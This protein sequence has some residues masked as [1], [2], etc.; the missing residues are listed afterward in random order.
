MANFVGRIVSAS[1][2][3]GLDRDRV[4]AFVPTFAAPED[5]VAPVVTVISASPILR[6]DPW[7][8]E[9]TDETGLAL[10]TIA[11]ELR[12]LA[13]PP[14][15]A[16]DGVAFS[17]QYSPG[18]AVEAIEDGFRFT[19]YRADGWIASPSFRVLAVDTGGNLAA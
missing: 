3:S 8:V 14:E 6:Y 15:V 5:G 2:G 16:F 11:V 19:L 12:G 4:G 10:I 1:I 9:V 7:I 18:S 17:S 13:R